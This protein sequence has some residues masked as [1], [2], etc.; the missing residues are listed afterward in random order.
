MV[1]CETHDACVCS[2]DPSTD[3]AGEHVLPAQM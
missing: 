2:L 1:K 3:K